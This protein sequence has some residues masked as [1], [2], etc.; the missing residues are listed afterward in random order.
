MFVCSWFILCT[1]TVLDEADCMAGLWWNI[2]TCLDVGGSYFT[3]WLYKVKLIVW[4][5]FFKI[6]LHVWM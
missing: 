3:H 6:S 2:S 1:L 4:L 5:A